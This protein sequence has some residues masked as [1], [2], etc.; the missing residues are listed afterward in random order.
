M[1]RE[2]ARIAAAEGKP[3]SETARALIEWGIKAHRAREAELLR[4][5]YSVDPKNIRD[6][7]GEPLVL[8]VAARW[9]HDPALDP[10]ICDRAALHDGAS[11]RAPGGASGDDPAG[12]CG[13]R[14][15]LGPRRTRSA[16]PGERR[17]GVARRRS[18]RRAA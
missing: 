3:E 7:D 9:V 17:S 13:W 1:Q 5:D 2:I 15:P 18:S 4:L 14:A 6:R 12:G 11:C 16:L 8:E 10:R